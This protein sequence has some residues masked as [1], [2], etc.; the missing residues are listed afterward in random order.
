MK[1]QLENV[2]AILAMALATY[3]TRIAGLWLMRFL[4]PG[5]AVQIALD[6][7]PVAVLTAAIAPALLKGGPAD[8]AAAALTC[9]AATRL[10]LLATVAI[11]VVSVVVLRSV[12]P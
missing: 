5:P 2:A 3:A 11:G 10:P 8:L 12:L 7:V 4:R 1:I 9:V 6:A